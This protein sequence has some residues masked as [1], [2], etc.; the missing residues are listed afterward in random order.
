MAALTSLIPSLQRFVAP[1]GLFETYFPNASDEDMVGSLADG[2]AECQLKGFFST[3]ELDVTAIPTV[4]PDL[5]TPQ[6]ALVVLFAGVRILQTEIRN[7]ATHRRQEAKGLVNEV[8]QSAGM[9][10]ELLK[11]YQ[12]EKKDLIDAVSRVGASD[13]FVM[14]DAY[15]INAT[16]RYADSSLYEVADYH[17]PF[18]GLL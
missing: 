10:V 1:P 7:R 11:E 3:F 8:D 6:G 18:G 12:Q 14:A 15:Y 13:V 17:D 16:T 2:F 5:T 4:T 9:L